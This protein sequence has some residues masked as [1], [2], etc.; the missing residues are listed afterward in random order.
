MA[1]GK[2]R[3]GTVAATVQTAQAALLESYPEF[4]AR[5][6]TPHEDREEHQKAVTLYE[7]YL[8][9]REPSS[10]RKADIPTLARLAQTTV[11]IDRYEIQLRVQGPT[12]KGGK[13]GTAD[14]EN[15]IARHLSWLY[16][17]SKQLAGSV[18]LSSVPDDARNL[19]RA[20]KAHKA[21]ADA[22]SKVKDTVDAFMV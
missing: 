9:A 17:K 20:A 10:W 7:G 21:A 5:F 11:E 19:G 12:I 15:P 18:G 4:P 1:N 3:R 22:V 13:H 2:A 14:V 16:S 8:E 6:V